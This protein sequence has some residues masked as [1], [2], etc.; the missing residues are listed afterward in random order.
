MQCRTTSDAVDTFKTYWY[1][2]D[3]QGNV[4]GI[5][6]D[7]GQKVVW[8]EY[9]AWG[10]NAYGAWVNSS[11]N[12]YQDLYYS[13][14][15]RYRGY[16]YDTDTGLYYLNSR[17]YDVAISRFISPDSI[18]T[19]SASPMGL[20]DKNLYAYCDNNPVMRRDDGGMFW[21]T[22]FDVVSL[23]FSVADVIK[24][25][26][27]PWAWVGLAADVVSLVVPFAT[28]GGTIVRAATKVDDVVDTVKAIDKAADVADAIGDAGRIANKIDTVNDI[29]KSVDKFDGAIDTYSNLRKVSKGTG[30][31]VHHIIEKRFIKDIP[32][33]GN[34]SQMGSVILSKAEHRVFTNKWRTL[35]KYGIQHSKDEILNAAIDIYEGYPS[36]QRYVKGILG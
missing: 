11:T 17:Y 20:T 1:E 27:D 21:D 22:V 13:N 23:C 34:A 26:D 14:P 24:N 12:E 18:S 28:G 36:L 31:E 9:D 4:I 25:P 10:M 8:Y 15:F 30:S 33:L 7:A 32:E 19:L 5:Y 6:T 2:K 35:S 29:A 3:M 16:Y